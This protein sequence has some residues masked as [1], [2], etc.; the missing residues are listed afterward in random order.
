MSDVSSPATAPVS[1]DSPTPQGEEKSSTPKYEPKLPEKVKY[2]TN[3]QEVEHTLEELIKRAQLADGAQ[4]RMQK[5][6]ESEKALKAQET[7]LK[8]NPYKYLVEHAGMKPQEAKQFLEDHTVDVLAEDHLSPEQKRIRE[9]EARLK[10]VDEAKAM[11]EQEELSKK[12]QQELQKMLVDIDREFEAAVVESPL[13]SSPSFK[14]L[15]KSFA[16]IIMQGA[17]DHGID[18]SPGDAMKEVESRI[19]QA[20]HPVLTGMEASQLKKFFGG[21]FL[22]KLRDSDVAALKQAEA[23]F[24][25]ESPS[26]VSKPVSS[27]P[28]KPRA[29][30]SRT[31]DELRGIKRSK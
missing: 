26:P 4:Y 22:K 5:A 14:P 15:A 1:P 25:K 21:D 10:A 30:I 27:D 17:E 20:I 29:S 6:A 28:V 16:S 19:V 3:G 31:F 9:M 12:E 11:A 2:K 7:L 18:L 8:T 23:P 13:L 24:R